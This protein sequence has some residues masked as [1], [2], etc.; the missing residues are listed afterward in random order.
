M[1]LMNKLRD[2]MP[3]VLAGMAGIFLLTIIFDW[4]A[5]GTIF[6]GDRPDANTIGMVNGQKITV[7]EY[8][9]AIN[10][11]SE[12]Q[13]QQS[14]KPDLTEADMAQ[15]EEQAWDQVVNEAL[16][17][18]HMRELNIQVTDQE[19]RD[20]LF[21][22]PPQNIVQQFTDSTGTFRQK[23]YFQALRDPKNDTAVRGMEAQ[24]RKQLEFSKWQSLMAAT[25]LVSNAELKQRFVNENDKAIIQFVKIAPSQP[26]STFVAQVT[27]D[28][29]KKYYNENKNKYKAEE[30]RR[31]RFVIFQTGPNARDSAM[32]K[33]NFESLRQ[34]IERAPL[35][36]IDTF[37]K[38]IANEEGIPF[39]GI[40]QIPPMAWG[41][42]NLLGAKP[43]DAVFTE[44]REGLAIT[45][46]TAIKDTNVST[47]H[48]RHI[49]IGFGTPE[50]R[51]SAKALA[52]K[53][54]IEIKGGADFA[55]HARQ[56]SMDGSAR[57][58]GDLGWVSPGQFVKE[59][60]QVA[61]SAPL[62]QVQPPV[63]SQFGYHIIEVL[64]RT[65]KVVYGFSIPVQIKASGKTVQMAQQQANI[66]RARAEED[67]FEQAAKNM[68]RPVIADVPPLEK[69]GQPLFGNK[70]FV[71]WAFEADKNDISQPVRVNQSQI[72]VVAQV[73]DIEP[74][75]FKKIEDVTQTIKSEIA[76]KLAV[77]SVAKRAQELR[78]MIA[79]GD[80]LG[81]LATVDTA[82]KP[83][84]TTIGPAEST[85][86][87]GVEYVINNAAY[88][89]KPGEI[90]Q[91]LKG[92]NAYYIVQTIS[93]QPAGDEAFAAKSKDLRNT[94]LQ[95]KQQRFL[96]NWLDKKKEKAEIED[97]RGPR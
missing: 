28:Q 8:Q 34:R 62:N 32:A 10:V 77:E 84:T 63:A 42:T 37:A 29:V 21:Y 69:K 80:S 89:M 64:E 26:V 12:Q 9:N 55:A 65:N 88:S 59:F 43:G 97:F 2:S 78:A 31:V 30:R 19:V 45:K 33:D 6:Q 44:G 96:M 73:T 70:S 52:D 41:K 67:G 93:H 49:L 94:I 46:I 13:K 5:Q 82:L 4:G 15:I 60:E 40:Q 56:Y 75:G 17:R 22:N 76:Q 23:E 87:A 68:D 50:N 48:S 81:K 36:G 35:E 20:Q 79:A 91:P 54:Y 11:L 58:G 61:T 85:P 83:M 90:S 51:D 86:G 72:I 53:L 25:T 71:D 95:E 74:A 3:W 24:L 38:E 39:Q 16:I 57:A 47:F 1:G 7:A 66:F 27:D 14:G 92:E 18:Q